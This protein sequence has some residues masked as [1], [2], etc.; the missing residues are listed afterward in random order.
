ML[1][2]ILTISQIITYCKFFDAFNAF[3]LVCFCDCV[4]YLA[5][6]SL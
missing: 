1:K 5:E 6:N 4:Y 2:L 3:N